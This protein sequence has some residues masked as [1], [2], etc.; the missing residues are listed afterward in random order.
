MN[1]ERYIRIIAG[2]MILASA[3]LTYYVSINWLWL[4]VFVGANLFQFGITKWCMLD[5]MLKAFGI[6]SSQE[7]GDNCGC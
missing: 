1:R 4:A 7:T 6:K 5:K 2:A 3:T